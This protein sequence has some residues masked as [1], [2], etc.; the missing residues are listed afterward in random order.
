MHP[1]DLLAGRAF[2]LSARKKIMRYHAFW[3]HTF[4]RARFVIAVLVGYATPICAQ[5][6]PNND[7]RSRGPHQETIFWQT[8]E[9]HPIEIGRQFTELYQGLSTLRHY[10]IAIPTR[11]VNFDAT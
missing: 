1:R 3:I 7:R 4:L 2:S 8:R 10:G 6:P 9:S 11:L 5:A